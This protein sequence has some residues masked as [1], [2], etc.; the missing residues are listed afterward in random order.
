ME[1]VTLLLEIIFHAC[2]CLIWNVWSKTELVSYMN[3]SYLC[4]LTLA[5]RSHHPWDGGRHFPAPKPGLSV[6]SLGDS[7][8]PGTIYSQLSDN[9][10]IDAIQ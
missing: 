3:K 10:S 2:S 6:Y 4:S 7:G 8:F 5:A 9:I 1:L